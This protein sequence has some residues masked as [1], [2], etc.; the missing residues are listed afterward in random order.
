MC[1][2]CELIYTASDNA[3][4]HGEHLVNAG[5]ISVT[6]WHD[7]TLDI[8]TDREDVEAEIK[9]N[10]CPMCGRK[11]ASTRNCENCG[12]PF[13]PSVR[14]DEIYCNRIFKN[15]R[16]CKQVGYENKINS[17][18][19][20]KSYRNAYKSKNAFKNRIIRKKAMIQALRDASSE[21]IK[22]EI[23]FKE[24]VCEAKNKMKQC[25]NGVIT[26][27]EFKEWLKE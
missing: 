7:K 19:V 2:Y 13:I 4:G 6:I 22:S 16:T 3:I 23:E 24:W 15:D 18:E 9:I 25:Q 12:K 20:M 5:N 17:D 11:L 8:S 1:K 27:E 26:L 14:S 10:Y 21:N